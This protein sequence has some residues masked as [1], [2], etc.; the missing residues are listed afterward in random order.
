M[1]NL[2]LKGLRQILI[3]QN[4][5]QITVILKFSFQAGVGM[6]NLKLNFLK[7]V[8]VALH[9]LFLQ[10]CALCHLLPKIKR[11]IACN[12]AIATFTIAEVERVP[13]SSFG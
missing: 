3:A 7:I 1:F 6:R 11:L 9:F 10:G 12:C 8:Q 5:F 4:Y 2:F 13:T